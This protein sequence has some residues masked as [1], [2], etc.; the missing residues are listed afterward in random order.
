MHV[1]VCVCVCVCLVC[2][3]VCGGGVLAPE[4]EWHMVYSLAPATHIHKHTQTNT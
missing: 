1:S 3:C 2:V 4:G